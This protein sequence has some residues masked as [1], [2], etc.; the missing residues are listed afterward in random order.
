MGYRFFI[1]WFSILTLFMIMNSYGY[2]QIGI[3]LGYKT[4]FNLN[5]ILTYNMYVP[6]LSSLFYFV[7]C[8]RYG[9]WSFF[10][11]MHWTISVV[12][13]FT[14]GVVQ[15]NH[16]RATAVAARQLGLDCYLFLRSSEQV[17]YTVYFLAM[18]KMN[19]F[20]NW[21]PLLDALAV[22]TYLPLPKFYCASSVPWRA[23]TSKW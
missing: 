13:I 23:P 3:N 15:S 19:T 22:W 20:L 10:W 6:V 18:Y 1:G 12:T 8:N 4:F 7:P 2:K 5:F 16:C 21:S 17:S 9:S 11:L 14:Y